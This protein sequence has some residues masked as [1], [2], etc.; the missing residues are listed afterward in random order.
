MPMSGNCGD[1]VSVTVGDYLAVST[2][3]SVPAFEN[4]Y[5]KRDTFVSIGF[6]IYKEVNPLPYQSILEN[7]ALTYRDRDILRVPILQKI[8]GPDK[9]AAVLSMEEIKE[10]EKNAFLLDKFI[11]KQI[12]TDGPI[13][14]EVF[15]LL[16]LPFFYIL[17]ASII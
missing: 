1:S 11:L 8:T 3:L 6:L 15:F 5:Y 12:C 16:F 10:R 9:Y 14:L 17:L 2:L 13:T 7:I 4:S